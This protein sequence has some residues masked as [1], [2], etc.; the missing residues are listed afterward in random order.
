MPTVLRIAGYEFFFRAGDC[1]EPPHIHVRGNGGTAKAWLDPVTLE[2]SSYNR[3][4]A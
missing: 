3:A 2:R 1:A 4:R